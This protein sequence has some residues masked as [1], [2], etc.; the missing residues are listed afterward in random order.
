MDDIY[1]QI[2]EEFVNSDYFFQYLKELYEYEEQ[3]IDI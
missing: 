1:Q 3:Y 2:H